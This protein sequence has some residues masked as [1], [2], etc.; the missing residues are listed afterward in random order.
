MRW[1]MGIAALLMLAVVLLAVLCLS[2]RDFALLAVNT[3]GQAVSLSR[4]TLQA[5]SSYCSSCTCETCPPAAVVDA[6]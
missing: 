6:Q 2:C 4:T 5:Q 1:A 3:D